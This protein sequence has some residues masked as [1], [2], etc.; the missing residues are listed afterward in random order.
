MSHFIS[1][2]NGGLSAF[3]LKRYIGVACP[4]AWRMHHK[5]MAAMA[6]HDDQQRLSGAVNAD[7]ACIDGERG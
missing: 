1:Q 4:T 3:E 2:A 5:I 6:G 7:D